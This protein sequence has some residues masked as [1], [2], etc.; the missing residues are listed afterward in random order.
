MLQKMGWTPGKGLGANEDGQTKQ[1]PVVLKLDNTGIGSQ[2]NYD[3]TWQVSI[4]DYTN[5][6]GKLKELKGEFEACIP[7]FQLL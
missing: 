3:D 2:K 4:K 6:L 7:D 5:V 1:V